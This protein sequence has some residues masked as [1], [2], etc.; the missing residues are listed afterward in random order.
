VA[1]FPDEEEIGVEE[2][3]AVLHAL[4]QFEP[5]GVFARDL[6]ECLLLQLRQLP[7]DTP[8]MDQARILIN[9]HCHQLP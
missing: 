8:W 6:Q 7:A 1:L 9:R 4:Q 2:V 5:T 3:T